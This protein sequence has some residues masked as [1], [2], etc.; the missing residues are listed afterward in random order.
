MKTTET[1][2]V[3]RT[4]NLDEQVYKGYKVECSEVK[5]Y[6]VHSENIVPMWY[7]TYYECTSNCIAAGAAP[8]YFDSQKEMNQFYDEWELEATNE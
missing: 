1:R 5:K 8:V 7:K 6:H 4:V 2:E 3:I